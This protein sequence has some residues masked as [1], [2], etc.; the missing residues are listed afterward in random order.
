LEGTVQY[1]GQRATVMGLGHF[2]GG[3]AA[4]RWLAGQGAIVT[5]TDLADE[6]A[7][8]SALDSLASVPITAFHLGGH[9]E[10][11]FRHADL[12]V[13]N[14]AVRPKNPWLAIAR[15]NGVLLSTE[16]DLFLAACPAD[17]IGV[18][19]SNGKSTTAAMIAA[20]L[21]A[22]G[23]RTWLGG[24]IGGSLL[25]RIDEIQLG[26]SV[27]LELSSFQLHYLRRETRLPH[28]GVITSFSPNHLDW[29]CDMDEYAAAKQI[30]L[31]RQSAGGMAVLNTRD[32]GLASWD[33]H[34]RGQLLTLVPDDDL[35]ALQVPGWHNRMNA[36]CAATAARAAGCGRAAVECGLR[37]YR[38]LP[39]RMELIAEI[40]GRR[41]Y[42]DSTSTTPESTM[43][44]LEAAPQPVYLLAGGRDKGFDFTALI[45][46]I[47]RLAAG[48][49]F[50]G[51]IGPKLQG[52]LAAA[53][54][55][56]RSISVA[57]LEEALDWC[58][59]S[60]GPGAAIV[61]SPGCSSHDQFR[62]FRERGERFGELVSKLSVDGYAS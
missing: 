41:F 22:D 39:Q 47:G 15:E 32:S 46:A 42:N 56:C 37:D 26:D 16:I 43:A 38:G 55:R 8:A 4:A 59:Q 28:I 49:A 50:F 3:A 25:D 5:V 44:A 20:I 62:N 52:R 29:H 9:R 18:T 13:V 12:I 51:E 33:R 54:G 53:L 21:Q 11:D 14:P 19:G 31:T 36:A 40:R 23:R 24:N 48:A 61:L 57:T 6:K 45:E 1:R 17:S 34:V 27:V 60:A 7:L 35:P 30:L 2:G 10:E 58:W